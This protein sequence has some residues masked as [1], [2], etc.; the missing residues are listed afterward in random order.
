[1]VV[2]HAAV[3]VQHAQRLEHVQRADAVDLGGVRRHVETD[4]HVTLCGQV[5]D[6]VGTDP[7][8][9]V[10]HAGGVGDVAVVQ[11][12][13]RARRVGILVQVVDAS[14]VES[15]RAALHAV[16]HVTLAEQ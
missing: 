4:V 7:G 1:M 3:R 9:K 2:A 14:G 11:E 15:R 12:D 8:E 6:L 10:E 5:V 13:P 16:H